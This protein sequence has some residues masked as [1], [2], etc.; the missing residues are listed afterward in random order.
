MVKHDFMD[1]DHSKSLDS[2]ST[3]HSKPMFIAF[4]KGISRRHERHEGS[5]VVT[6][7]CA[8]KHPLEQCDTV[9]NDL[10]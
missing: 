8:P 9:I 1:L 5:S 3:S 4:I 7:K 2:T 10:L 6:I